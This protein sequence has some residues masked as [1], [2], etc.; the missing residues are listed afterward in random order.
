MIAIDTDSGSRPDDASSEHGRDAGTPGDRH[1]GEKGFVLMT[2]MLV[3]GLLMGLTVTAHLASQAETRIGGN[4]YSA[5]RAFYAAEAGAEHMLAELREQ[6]SDGVLTAAKADSADDN[7]PSLP[8]HQFEEYTADLVGGVKNEKITQGPFSGMWSR[9]REVLVT[10]SVEGPAGSRTTV[11][12]NAKALAIPIFQFAAFYNEDLEVFPG[13][14]MDLAGRVHT[15]EQLYMASCG[16]TDIYNVITVSGHFHQ[17]RKEDDTWNN[18]CVSPPEDQIRLNDGSWTAIDSDVHDF[19]SGIGSDPS[20]SCSDAD[21]QTFIDYSKANWDNNI[22]TDAHGIQPLTLPVP[23]GTP[24]HVLVEPCTGSEPTAIADVKY[25]CKA[26]IVVEVDGTSVNVNPS[27]LSGDFAEYQKNEFYDDREQTGD[28]GSTYSTSNRDVIELDVA[29]LDSTEYGSGIVYVTASAAGGTS[30]DA[31][32]YVVRLVNGEDLEAPLTVATNLPMYVQGDYNTDGQWQPASL[33][34]DALTILSNSW[35]DEDSDDN[36]DSTSGEYASD[37]SI[38]AAILAGHTA[39]P[40]YGSPNPGGQFE[41]FPRFLEDWGSATAEIQGSFIS[42]WT[43][44]FADSDWECCNYYGPPTRDWRFDTR[45]EDP[46]NFPP[47]TPVVGQILRIG[48][49][50]T[51]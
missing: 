23:D 2:V 16:G 27:G 11:E 17:H 48:F 5:T 38:Q 9:T 22:Q 51:Y 44:Q 21:E 43:S 8:M 4:D 3:L 34:A 10:S 46:E 39:T 37:T 36:E 49:V 30:A 6:L 7:P 33:A 19:C 15:N 35:D 20:P 24:P 42:L 41:N 28:G 25:A 14:A 1:R 12:L 47:G 50:R 32:Q 18:V 40:S 13:A 45:F 29:E 26:N 31:T